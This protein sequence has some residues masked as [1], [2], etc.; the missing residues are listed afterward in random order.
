MR[1][2]EHLCLL[3][4]TTALLILPFQAEAAKADK[5]KETN[6]VVRITTSQGVIEIELEAKRAPEIGRAHV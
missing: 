5:S 6:P 1:L 2:L 4:V 3:V